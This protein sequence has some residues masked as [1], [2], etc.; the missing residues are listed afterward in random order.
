MQPFGGNVPYGWLHDPAGRG[1]GGASSA[2]QP[3]Q[4]Y[5]KAAYRAF[6]GRDPSDAERV[7]WAAQLDD[8][9][10]RATLTT[11]LA[12]SQEWVTVQLRDLYE[13]VLGPEPDAGG[14]AYWTS[15]VQSGIRITDIGTFFYGSPEY[16]QRAGGA[17]SPYVTSLYQN[18]LHRSPDQGGLDHWVGLLDAGAPTTVAADFY[19][20]IESRLDRVADLY[21]ALLDALRRERPGLLGR[22]ARAARRHRAGRHTRR[23]RRVLHIDLQS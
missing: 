6:I 15:R 23:Q 18:I 20:S 16:Y 2:S 17:N 4:Q 5:V 21:Q 11:T 14:A 1:G 12:S 22:P 13:R 9:T 7:N 8:G 19:A 3:N 10:P